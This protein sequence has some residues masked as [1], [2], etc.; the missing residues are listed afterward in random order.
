M[1]N[2][3]LNMSKDFEADLIAAAKSG[4]SN[5]FEQLYKRYSAIINNYISYVSV[6]RS[7]RDDLFQEGLIGLLKAIRTYDNI[8]SSFA[9]YASLCIKRSIISALRK[10]NRN[11]RIVLSANPTIVSDMND[12]VPSPETDM[13]NNEEVNQR[14][15][16]FIYTLSKFE[17]NTFN[18]YITGLSY[19]SMA[20]KLNCSEKSIDNAVMRIKRKLKTTKEQ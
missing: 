2:N 7:E 4:D 11:N 3:L 10:Y 16:Q 18:L 15:E 6:P 20:K 5:A 17:R 14:Y 19:A 1:S 8:S 12:Y 9:T 13:V